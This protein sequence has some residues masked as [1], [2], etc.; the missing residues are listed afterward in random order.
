MNNEMIKVEG[1]Y[2]S[3]GSNQVLKGIDVTIAEQEVV[4]VIGPSGGGKSTF[5]R[6]LNYL[7]VPTAGTI[8]FDGIPLNGEANINEVRQEVG[9]VFQKFNLFPHMTV[10]DN[11]TLAPTIV[12]HESKEEAVENAQ[13]YLDK[14]GLLNKADAYPA[15]LSGGQQQRVAIARALCMKP[16]AMLFDEPTSALDPEMIN[17]VLDVMKNLAQEGMTMVVV[18]HEM[19]FAREVGDRILFLDGGKILE[20]GDPKEFFA[21]PK[22]ERAQSFLS[23]IL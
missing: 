5:L 22:N 18:T 16:K 17:E 13:K 15:S 10:M 14:V 6:C 12:R 7:E 23:K 11:L 21:H 4:V 1:L 19:G 20:Q 3:Y 9:M 2:K 8:T